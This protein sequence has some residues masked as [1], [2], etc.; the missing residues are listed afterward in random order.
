VD[1]LV[2]LRSIDETLYLGGGMIRNAVWDHLHGYGSPTPSDDVDVIHFNPNETEK[3][4][5]EAI[6]ARLASLVPNAKWSVKNQARMHLVNG[7]IAYSSLDDAIYRWPETATAFVARLDDAGR[8]E[9]V[10]PYGFDDLL[11]LLVT[12]TPPFAG[13]IDVIRKRVK[14]KQWQRFWPRLRL[15]LP[16]E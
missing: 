1:A 15:L 8:V 13:R 4:H 10:A 2:A 11:R 5:D 6:Q 3:R 14:E 7:E 12:N 16:S 9:F